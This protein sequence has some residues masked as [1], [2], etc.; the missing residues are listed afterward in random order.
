MAH[1]RKRL[2]DGLRLPALG[3]EFVDAGRVGG[4]WERRPGDGR[5]ASARQA[6]YSSNSG[7]SSPWR[8]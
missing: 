4:P 7:A 2:L 5:F 1:D 6:K 8:K 3:V